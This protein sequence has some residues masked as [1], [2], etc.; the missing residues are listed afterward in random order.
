MAGTA[1]LVLRCYGGVHSHGDMLWLNPRLPE[2]V[3]LLRFEVLYR[4]QW[5]EVAAS[6]G[7]TV[8]R[9]RPCAAAPI[10]LN[11]AGLEMVVHAGETH[12]VVEDMQ[13]QRAPASG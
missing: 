12:E 13:G 3:T 5:V 7:R 1:D 11:V 9:L 10:R 8:V 2:E 6:Q 4:G